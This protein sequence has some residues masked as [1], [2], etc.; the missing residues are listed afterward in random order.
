MGVGILIVLVVVVTAAAAV[1]VQARRVRLETAALAASVEHV[2]RVRRALDAVRTE[3]GA[4]RSA[5]D[6]TTDLFA[7]RARR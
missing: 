7:R 5:T 4:T 2:G 1:A 6:T 3:A